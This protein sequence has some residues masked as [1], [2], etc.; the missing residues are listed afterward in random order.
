MPLKLL[1]EGDD[2]APESYYDWRHVLVARAGQ[3]IARIV[4]PTDAH[5]D[6]ND[7][8][9][10]MSPMPLLGENIA[11]AEDGVTVVAKA[12]GRVY[13][14]DEKVWISDV[15]EIV[16]DVDFSTG[17]IDYPNDIVIGGSVRDLFTVRSATGSVAVGGTIEAANV[18]AERDVQVSGGIAGRGKGAVAAGGTLAAKYLDKAHVTAGGDVILKN[19]IT[20]SSVIC[21]GDLLAR[22]GSV[23]TSDLIVTGRLEAGTVGSAAG[24]PLTVELG[25]DAHFR[26][27]APPLLERTEAQLARL[28][29]MRR[30]IEPIIANLKLL[31]GAQRERATEWLFQ[32]SQ[33]EAGA[34]QL[35]E[36]LDGLYRRAIAIAHNSRMLVQNTLHAGVLIRFYNAETTVALA[37]EGPLEVKLTELSG[38]RPM[39]AVI[40]VGSGPMVALE[41]RPRKDEVFAAVE[42][43]LSRGATMMPA[44]A[45]A[46]ALPCSSSASGCA[47]AQQ[48]EDSSGR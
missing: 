16:R 38:Q 14:R 34:R 21:G 23:L 8:P 11:L 28:E 4:V 24:F 20:A 36:Q 44:V 27:A 15:L 26:R 19:D 40:D 42:R 13:L 12:A 43:V 2:E 17:N 25:H 41:T 46:A 7:D 31:N 33:I 6:D 37:M 39:I 32:A 10:A 35:L 47:T 5:R 1:I 3:P 29:E 30:Q 48:R 9:L 22:N 18:S 45:S